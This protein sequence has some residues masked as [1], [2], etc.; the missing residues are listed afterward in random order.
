M[1][2]V[3]TNTNDWSNEKDG[4]HISETVVNTT[5]NID[6]TN[7]DTIQ[8]ENA[9]GN[10]DS[11]KSQYDSNQ[12]FQD[13]VSSSFKATNGKQDSETDF[14]QLGSSDV[15]KSSKMRKLFNVKKITNVKPKKIRM[16]IKPIKNNSN[17]SASIE[18]ASIDE[19][20]IE[21]TN[22][23]SNTTNDR[24]F[25]IPFPKR[26]QKEQS[27]NQDISDVSSE[28]ET[29]IP[30]LEERLGEEA[31][32]Q[33]RQ[34]AQEFVRDEKGQFMFYI[35]PARYVGNPKNPGPLIRYSLPPH[36]SGTLG[37]GSFGLEFDAGPPIPGYDGQYG[38]GGATVP[39]V[40]PGP[41][42]PSAATPTPGA[43]K[44][45]VGGGVGAK[46]LLS[47]SS[48]KPAARPPTE[49][50][51]QQIDKPG[52]KSAAPPPGGVAGGLKG[53]TKENVKVGKKDKK[54]LHWNKVPVG[55]LNG[56]VWADLK[57]EDIDVD[58][59]ELDDL[60]GVDPSSTGGGGIGGS[61]QE[62][63]P[64]QLEILPHKRKHN[65]NVLLATLKM[66]SDDIK[67][68]VRQLKYK[69]LDEDKL[70]ALVVVS[71]T[72]EEETVLREMFAEKEKANR[73]DSFMM[74]LAQLPGLRGKLQC[75]L[76]AKTFDEVARDV[77]S[78]MKTFTKIPEEIMKSSKLLKILELV[79]RVGNMLN[80]GT[81][82]GGAH[83][84]KLDTL[85]S[86]RTFKSAKGIT[87][88]Q[89]IVRLLERKYPGILPIE[90]ELSHLASSAQI[91][92]EGIGED[93]AQ[94]L[95]SITTVTEQVQKIGDDPLLAAFKAEMNAF[96]NRSFHIRDQIVE[97]RATLVEKLQTMMEWFGESRNKANRGRQEEILKLLRTFVE[98]LNTAKKQNELQDKKEAEKAI[99]AAKTAASKVS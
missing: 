47:G 82:R 66:S 10:Q 65:I 76:S 96:A 34:I 30:T 24:K 45:K 56:T 86:L 80:G 36:F 87:L 91:S 90:D 18:T 17:S 64:Q 63:Q 19:N 2:A 77:I 68:V 70:Q 16:P 28:D 21:S 14:A 98:D 48:N 52:P 62:E 32:E 23:P 69:E 40:P 57:D 1:A 99:K 5:T 95:D 3:V 41:P 92:L 58:V 37:A 81:N 6:N 97:L 61:A 26:G 46:P 72:E 60:F 39:G 54:A 20:D 78:D 33:L 59:D 44:P 9:S 85:P 71:P 75:A 8:K 12:K 29:P 22:E 35:D 67:D 88:V 4:L 93:V 43:A 83:G 25:R 27:I 38:P 31:L 89:Y 94:V 79:L 7:N 84:F 13:T 55:Q 50:L 51:P 42:K 73:T 53:K 49:G 15:D 74:E 11:E